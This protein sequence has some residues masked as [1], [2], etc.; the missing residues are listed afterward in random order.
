MLTYRAEYR[1]NARM[2]QRRINGENLQMLSL[3]LKL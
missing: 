2:E 3:V 1:Q